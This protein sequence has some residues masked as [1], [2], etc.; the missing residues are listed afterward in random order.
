MDRTSVCGT[1]DPG[2]IPGEGTESSASSSTR[3]GSS[4][5][6]VIKNNKNS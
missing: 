5:T 2:S 1:G 4:N 3:Q 6:F